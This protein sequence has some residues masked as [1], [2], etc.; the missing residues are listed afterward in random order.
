MIH[1]KI[2]IIVCLYKER[3]MAVRGKEGKE[4]K[5]RKGGREEDNA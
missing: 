4:G 3:I 1:R 2:R 5:G